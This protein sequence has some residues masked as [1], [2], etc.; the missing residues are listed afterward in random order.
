MLLPIVQVYTYN[1][2]Y[3]LYI[4]KA[5][6]S[7]YDRSKIIIWYY[8]SITTVMIL[9]ITYVTHCI[10]LSNYFIC[11]DTS[12]PLHLYDKMSQFLSIIKSLVILCFEQ[13]QFML[14]HYATRH[15]NRIFNYIGI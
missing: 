5:Y 12:I 15:K 9:R 10:N 8:Y 7:N 11:T 6:S 14:T 4:Y 13:L 3:P 2:C 1:C